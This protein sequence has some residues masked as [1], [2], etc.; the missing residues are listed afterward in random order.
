MYLNWEGICIKIVVIKV[1]FVGIWDGLYYVYFNMGV[2]LDYIMDG[3]RFILIWGLFKIKLW[4]V[5]FILFIF[6]FSMFR[7]MVMADRVRVLL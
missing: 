4:M 3:G 1:E 6:C 7:I 5:L 2:I